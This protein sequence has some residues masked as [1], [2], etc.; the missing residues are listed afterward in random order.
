MGN[1]VRMLQSIF[2]CL[3]EHMVMVVH[4]SNRRLHE[5]QC[6]PSCVFVNSFGIVSTSIEL[7]VCSIGCPMSLLRGHDESACRIIAADFCTDYIMIATHV[8]VATFFS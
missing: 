4:H 7:C 3:H 5:L 1:A 6:Y 2:A 8:F